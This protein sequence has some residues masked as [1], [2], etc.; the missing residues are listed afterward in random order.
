LFRS[1]H[2]GRR[3]RPSLQPEEVRG[4]AAAEHGALAGGA[5][6][7][8]VASVGTG[9]LV[10]DPIHAAVILKQRTEGEPLPD[11]LLRHAGSKELCACDNAVRS[12]CQTGDL[13]INVI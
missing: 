10:A 7:G 12:G 2:L 3:R 13:P 6:R 4:G 1:R 8:E 9:S 11:L 5:D